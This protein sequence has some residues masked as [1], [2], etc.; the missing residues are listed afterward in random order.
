MYV[1]FGSY[2]QAHDEPSPSNSQHPRTLDCLYM[3]FVSNKQGGH[4]L[5]D[6]RTGRLITRRKI[7]PMPMTQSVIDLVHGLATREKMPDGLKIT[8]KTGQVLYDSSCLAGVDYT[9]NA[10]NNATKNAANNNYYSVLDSDDSDDDSDY[11][12]DEEST[13][14]SDDEESYAGSTSSETESEATDDATEEEA[15]PSGVEQYS[16]S[17]RP[18]KAPERLNLLQC[19][20]Q[21]QGQEEESYTVDTAKVIATT[22]HHINMVLCK[23]EHKHHSFVETYSLKRGIKTFG[24]RAEEGAAH[25]M[26]QLHKRTAFAPINVANITPK[27]RSRAMESFIFLVEKRDG[28]IKGRTV[29]NGNSQRP[30][31]AKV[32]TASPT[33]LTESIMLTAV[34]EA[35]EERDVMT[36][37][38]PNAFVQTDVDAKQPGERIIMKIKGVLVDMLVA[39]DPDLYGPNVT[40]EHGEKVLYV[41]VL[42][43]IYGMLQSSLL[44]YKK[45]RADIESIG[46][47]VNPYDP[48]VANRVVNDQQHTLTWH[49]D[50]VKSSHKDSKVNDQFLEWLEM[51]YASDGIGKVKA[52]R[53]SRHDY[54]GM[55]LDYSIKGAVQVDMADYVKNMVEDFP[56]KLNAEN[57]TYPWNE[58]LFKVDPNSPALS[59]SMASDFYTFVYKALFVSKRARQ[60]ILP[61]VSFLTTRV[62]APTQQDW[63]KLKKL[64]RFL[65]RTQDDVLT[66]EAKDGIQIDWHLDAAFAVHPDYKSHTGATMTLGKGTIQSVSAKQKV[67]TRSSTEAE[68]VSND[69]ILSKV[70]WTRRFLEAQEVPINE[71][72]LHRDNTS[73][74]RLETNGKASSGKRTRHFHIKYFYIT[75]L[76]ERKELSTKF[77][78]TDRMTADYMSKPLTGPKFDKFRNEIM[79]FKVNQE[80]NKASVGQQE[81]VGPGSSTSHSKFHVGG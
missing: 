79:N 12:D 47:V 15:N 80:V 38:I 19:H 23:K 73:A 5:L 54:L 51:K 22:M 30:Y 17:G 26:Q 50:D 25:E 53:G 63:F 78:P 58:S 44:Y 49:V 66:L 3:R 35:K 74:M 33:V 69:D 52:T 21:A 76:I 9:T 8:T 36:A 14:Q 67:N 75:D 55:H 71:N 18:V 68:F 7:T 81:C 42:K 64:M 56:E 40:I 6:L 27:E 29:A 13:S 32:D 20:M 70:I 65:K 24:K 1:P 45:F 46:F 34:I 11:E 10:T 62:R 2:V 16:R 31:T 4:E 41:V 72:N 48:C 43:A 77:C 61:G 59:K 28:Q 60:D 39:L 57:A 37:D